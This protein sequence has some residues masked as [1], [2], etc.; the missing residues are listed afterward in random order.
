[1]AEGYKRIKGKKVK[2]SLDSTGGV[3][4]VDWTCPY[5]WNF[6]AGFYHCEDG[7][8][9]KSDFEFN[10][11]CAKCGKVSTIECRNAKPLFERA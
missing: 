3:M 8:K 9:L 2:V 6:H 4:S 11:A 5:C 7:E 1:M 10:H